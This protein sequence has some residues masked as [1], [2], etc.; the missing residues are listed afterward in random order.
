M[1]HPSCRFCGTQLAITIPADALMA[2]VIRSLSSRAC[3]NRCADYRR[4][5]RDVSDTVQRIAFDLQ[6]AEDDARADIITKI[7]RLLTIVI[8][9]VEEHYLV[10]G[11][12]QH[13]EE[14][15]GNIVQAPDYAGS[16]IT[17]FEREVRKEA[18]S[19]HQRIAA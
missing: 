10:S 18:K 3:C 11:Y 17:I 2:R 15:V 9:V 12:Q 8:R 19:I 1:I 14:F 16:Q 4:R 5:L 6:R 7:R 13:L